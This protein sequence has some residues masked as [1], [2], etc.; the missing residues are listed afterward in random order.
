MYLAIAVLKPVAALTWSP[1]A[2]TLYRSTRTVLD[3]IC[4]MASTMR[5]R[6]I[7]V[8]CYAFKVIVQDSRMLYKVQGLLL[9]T[10]AE[11]VVTF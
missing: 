7:A 2:Q 8:G 4:N 1:S 5:K 11:D 6:Y 10:Y 9:D 3:L